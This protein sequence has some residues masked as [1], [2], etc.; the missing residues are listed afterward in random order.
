MHST[1]AHHL[2]LPDTDSTASC[3]RA[4]NCGSVAPSHIHPFCA[5]EFLS[6]CEEFLAY[7]TPVSSSNN[8]TRKIVEVKDPNK[9]GRSDISGSLGPSS[10]LLVE[11]SKAADLSSESSKWPH[12]YSV[13]RRTVYVAGEGSRFP[14]S[15]LATG[16]TIHP[17]P[18]PKT[19]TTFSSRS[20]PQKRKCV[21]TKRYCK[22]AQV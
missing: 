18:G 20:H 13:S 15:N 11:K 16:R 14:D 3:L 17:E 2:A 12:G 6:W 5:S 19:N 7:V 21:R 8:T 10:I 22:A 4:G 1:P 9:Q